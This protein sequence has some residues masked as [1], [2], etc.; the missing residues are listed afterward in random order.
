MAG[1]RQG[2]YF[3]L[4]LA[5][6]LSREAARAEVERLARDVLTN[7]VI[8]RSVNGPVVT[9]I[10]GAR[11]ATSTGEGNNAIRGAYLGRGAVLDG[12]TITN[13]ATQF[14]SGSSILMNGGGGVCSESAEGIVTNCVI[15]LNLGATV[16]FSYPTGASM[17]NADFGSGPQPTSCTQGAGPSTGSVPP[18]PHSPTAP[19]WSGTSAPSGSWTASSGR[20]AAPT[21]GTGPASTWASWRR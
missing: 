11:D 14:Y 13:G 1:V 16:N 4:A 19:G 12:F 3:E 18:L 21:S 9:T 10:A 6:G 15:A 8:V 20:C 2:K 7:P 5:D 17:H